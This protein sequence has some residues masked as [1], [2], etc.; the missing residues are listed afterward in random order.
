ML[1]VDQ[2][3]ATGEE[4]RRH[5]RPDGA[6][7]VYGLTRGVGV[8]P[9][10]VLVHGMASNMTRWTEFIEQTGLSHSW[11]LLRLDLRGHGRS[12]WRGRIG[13]EIW[14][15]DLAAILEAEHYERAVVGG[16]CLGANFAL[17]F[18]HRY[19]QRTQGLVLVEPMPPAALVG[20]LRH[21]QPLTPLLT[22]AAAIIR[23]LNSIG[24]YRRHLEP[25]NLRELD[26]VTRVAM[27]AQGN[28]DALSRRYASPLFDLR[29]LPTANYVQDFIEVSRP[30]PAFAAIHSP[31]LAL[32]S[33]GR[34][35][36]DPQIVEAVMAMLPGVCLRRINALHW[37]PTEQPQAMREAIEQGCRDFAG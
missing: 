16:H 9:L 12:T 30:L 15:D 27:A 23:A 7:L 29:H 18:A 6:V 34:H 32:I 4:I 11:D 31:A 35:F 26:A 3:T 25:L 20:M 17:H 14:S 28:A 37:I 21:I 22:A 2:S 13:M 1:P 36:T 10:L 19:P 24:I 8:R 5:H 33:N